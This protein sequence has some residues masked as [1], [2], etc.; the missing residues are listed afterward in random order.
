MLEPREPRKFS[1][2]DTISIALEIQ[3]DS[4][5]DEVYAHFVNVEDR[6]HTIGL[7]GN[8][9]GS[10]R[11]GISM[12]ARTATPPAPGEYRCEYIHVRDIHGNF[13]V[14]YPDQEICFRVDGTAEAYE[15][16]GLAS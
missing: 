3:D 1:P 4:G 2:S 9:G 13:T 15:P 5:V 7:H 10:T 12:E 6:K 14:S 16:R 8:G 11:L